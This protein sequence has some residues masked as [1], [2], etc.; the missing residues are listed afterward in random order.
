MANVTCRKF[1]FETSIRHLTWSVKSKANVKMGNRNE[2]QRERNVVKR[3]GSS[4][5]HHGISRLAD[6]N[7][8]MVIS[9]AHW[10]HAQSLCLC[11]KEMATNNGIRIQSW[12]QTMMHQK[13]IQENLLNV[14]QEIILKL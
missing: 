1:K 3:R 13:T 8:V 4:K 6:P 12:L 11:R 10:L 5:R 2:G 14:I 9:T 7:V